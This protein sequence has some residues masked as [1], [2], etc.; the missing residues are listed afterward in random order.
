MFDLEIEDAA[1]ESNLDDL[2][3]MSMDETKSLFS[4]S[5]SIG[6]M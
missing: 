6:A 1:I 2:V 5:P 3:D 4:K